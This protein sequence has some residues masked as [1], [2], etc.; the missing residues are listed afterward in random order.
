MSSSVLINGLVSFLC[1]LRSLH[2]RYPRG[3]AALA[4]NP[5]PPALLPSL[6]L[7]R[8]DSRFCPWPQAH[9]K[10]D[11]VQTTNVVATAT[12]C[13]VFQ[14][15]CQTKT[16]YGSSCAQDADCCSGKCGATFQANICCN[17]NGAYCNLN[18]PDTCCSGTCFNSGTNNIDG[19]CG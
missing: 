4:Y 9:E 7:L 11:I 15:V 17:P 16:G 2:P 14:P 13:V 19:T 3:A 6:L 18:D 8:C 12:Q 5:K 10:A 1:L